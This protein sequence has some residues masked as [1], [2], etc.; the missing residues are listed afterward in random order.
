[1]IITLFCLLV[2]ALFSPATPPIGNHLRLIP[3]VS[4]LF[5]LTLRPAIAGLQ[6]T[7]TPLQDLARRP[8]ANP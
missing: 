3:I 8:Y 6:R 5:G 2:L 1:M 4:Q 7:P